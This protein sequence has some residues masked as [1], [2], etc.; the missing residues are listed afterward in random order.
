MHFE[1]QICEQIPHLQRYALALCR[2]P[3][4]A[5]DLVQDCLERALRKRHLWRWGRLRPWL[6][7]MLYNLYLNHRQSASQR[8][9]IVTA[10]AGE[11]L[12]TASNQQPHAECVRALENIQGLP[13]DQR[14]ALLLVVLEGTSYRESARILS[15]QVGTLRSRLARA[16]E[17]L[18][19]QEQVAS[20]EVRPLRRV[21]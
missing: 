13:E 10:E 15:I 21:K 11:E 6:F 18:R 4:E 12:T 7:R 16:R 2:N 3:M 20:N 1:K 8:R 9:E 17:T 14:T 19:R 5:D